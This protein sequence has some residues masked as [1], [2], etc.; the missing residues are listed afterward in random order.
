[1]NNHNWRF[2]FEIVAAGSIVLSL[3]FVGIELR[4]TSK[5]ARFQAVQDY[6]S[7]I[8][9]IAEGA[10]QD[11]EL[12]ERLFIVLANGDTSTF[13][14]AEQAQMSLYFNA[15]LNAYQGLF[16]S[17][18]EGI[19][20]EDYLRILLRSSALK[21]DFLKERWSGMSATFDEDFIRY[22]DEAIINTGT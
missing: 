9:G 14:R 20:S 17:V 10:A 12:S 15:M 21:S 3:I 2:V 7:S 8:A 16:Q 11:L 19:L 4:Q 22:L 5:F 18:R 13:T 1:M 6:S